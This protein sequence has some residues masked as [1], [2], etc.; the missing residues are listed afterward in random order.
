MA[1]ICE[2]VIFNRG[3]M[4]TIVSAYGIGTQPNSKWTAVL[5]VA[6]TPMNQLFGLYRKLFLTVTTQFLADPLHVSID[7][8][9]TMYQ[10]DPRTLQVILDSF[11][12][13]SL[14][15]VAS[16]P[17]YT[18]KVVR[19]SD[20]FR[21]NYNVDTTLPGANPSTVTKPEDRTELRIW[22]PATDMQ[23]FYDYC[24]VSVNGFFYRTQTDG[25]FVYIP[26]GGKSLLNS[27][28][29]QLGF[30]SF[31]EISKIKQI[32]LTASMFYKNSSQSFLSK[33]AY[34]DPGIDVTGKTVL[35]V[36]GGYLYL[37]GTSAFRQ[38]GDRS[39]LIDFNN[40]PL[41]DRYY[42]AAKFLDFSSLGLTSQAKTSDLININEFLSDDVF[43]KYLT[44]A[45]SFLVVLDVPSLYNL[46]H[47]IKNDGLPGMLRTYTEP[48]LPLY[49]ANGQ[50]AEYWKILDQDVWAM[51][52]QNSDYRNRV[53]NSVHMKNLISTT[54]KDMPYRRKYDSE[55]Y[56]LELGT[57]VLVP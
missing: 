15:T 14:P 20:G 53:M 35:A 19:Y 36:I 37:P 26:D 49:Y 56:L 16:V 29:N 21:S 23:R 3:F 40:V 54:G 45:Q 57:D 41:F 27:N 17:Q 50:V 42:D 28:Q 9:R 11:G 2:L 6:N 12:G 38:V 22:R 1:P 13:S 47:P 33:M 25:D 18:S 48:T 55:G 8:L 32:K 51:F 43:I 4:Y 39:F 10:N 31:E 34:F 5:N 52:V 7:D 44:H 24:M 30:H 46:R